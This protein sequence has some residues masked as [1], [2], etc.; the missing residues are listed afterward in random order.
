MKKADLE[1]EPGAAFLVLKNGITTAGTDSKAWEEQKNK[2]L[3]KV[4][5]Q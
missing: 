5:N 4:Y 3:A 2:S 1:C